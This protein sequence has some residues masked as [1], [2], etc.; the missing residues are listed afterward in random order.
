M[1]SANPTPD[2]SHSSTQST[3]PS[4]PATTNQRTLY[5]LSYY[6]N[7]WL[8]GVLLRGQSN[9]HSTTFG[10]LSTYTSRARA[11]R[12]GRKWVLEQLEKRIEASDPPPKTQ[13]YKEAAAVRWLECV[14]EGEGVWEYEINDG[15]GGVLREM[16]VVRVEGFVVQG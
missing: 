9:P 8:N 16:L 6:A 11:T 13:E 2:S 15:V 5:V 12:R 10:L 3:E 4:N 14:R 7:A 1:N